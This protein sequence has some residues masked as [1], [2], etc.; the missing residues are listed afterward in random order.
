MTIDD[1]HKITDDSKHK[2]F[3]RKSR[4]TSSPCPVNLISEDDDDDDDQGLLAACINIGMQNNRYFSF[5]GFNIHLGLR[6]SLL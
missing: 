3:E 1:E 6:I 5:F 4:K 2:E